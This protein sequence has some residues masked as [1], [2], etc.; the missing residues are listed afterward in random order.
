MR[1]LKS[2]KE[3]WILEALEKNLSSLDYHL[4]FIILSTEGG[5]LCL[6]EKSENDKKL[7]HIKEKRSLEKIDIR[8]KNSSFCIKMGSVSLVY[9]KGFTYVDSEPFFCLL[10]VKTYFLELLSFL[11]CGIFKNKG[12]VFFFNSSCLYWNL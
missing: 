5:Y 12:N 11:H 2:L 10:S 1:R 6:V 4:S 7:Q 9:K 3:R 8:I